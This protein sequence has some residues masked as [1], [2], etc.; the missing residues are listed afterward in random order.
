MNKQKK[1]QFLSLLGIVCTVTVSGCLQR[2]TVPQEPVVKTNFTKSIRATPIERV[3]LLLAIDNSASMG[4]KQSI[5]QEAI[6]DLINRL[7]APHCLDKSTDEFVSNSQNGN[8]PL[9]SKIEFPPVH[10]LHIGVVTSSL[11]PR[12]TPKKGISICDGLLISPNQPTATQYFD[13]QGHLVYRTT[14][15]NQPLPPDIDPSR[16]LAWYPTPANPSTGGNAP[17]PPSRPTI[18]D[19]TQLIQRS[20]EIVAVGETGCG[21]E[22]QMEDW[23]RF[24]IQPDPYSSIDTSTETAQWKGIDETILKQRHDFLRPDSAVVIIE[25]SDENYSEIDVRALG[26]QGYKFLTNNLMPRP[27]SICATNPMSPDCTSC[28]MT[29]TSKNDPNCLL[30]KGMFTDSAKEDINNLR[31]VHMKQ[32]Y[33]VDVQFPLSRY[34]NGLTSSKIPN[35]DGEYPPGENNYVGNPTCTNPLFAQSLPASN[36]EELCN[37][38]LGNRPPENIFYVHIGGIPHQLLHFDAKD[39]EKSRLT[40]ADWIKILG[41]DPEKYDFTGIDPHM[42]ESI[43]PRD[44]I[45]KAGAGIQAKDDADPIHGRE[46]DTS[47]IKIIGS[48]DLQYACTFPLT[49]PRDC[50]KPE[51]ALSC[52]CPAEDSFTDP[53]PPLCD[54]VQKHLQI[55]A[56]VYPTPKMLQLAKLL[57]DQAAISS[58]CPIDM[59]KSKD[60]YGYRPAIASL[61]ERLKNALGSQCLPQRLRPDP[62]GRV[63]CLVL[64]TINGSTDPNLC[65][66]P[67]RR[68]PDPSIMQQLQDSSKD[69]RNTNVQVCEIQQQAVVPGETCAEDPDKLGFCYVE[70]AN[71]KRPASKCDQAIIINLELVP[72]SQFSLQCIQQVLPSSQPDGSRPDGGP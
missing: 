19:P 12:M 53:I 23:Y 5:L 7:V 25:I 1:G 14:D 26:G 66:K 27:T 38:P 35:R 22:S 48:R 61:M 49:T 32:R 58:L 54:P 56:K 3:D 72:N 15:P 59:D 65:H 45:T 20:Q 13:D 41:K 9:G 55:R 40:N 33:G 8:C 36:N 6:P 51:N 69:A 64:E 62:D 2:P 42:I 31:H 16:F 60:T 17:P 28:R 29:T 46:W 71:G 68:P 67:G 21:I 37:L 47:S 44:A 50:S 34:F 39:P 11:G 57:G 70:K 63:S 52:D 43:E 4:D 24:L 18:K 10:D 30:T